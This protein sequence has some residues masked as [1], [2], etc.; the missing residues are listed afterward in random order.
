MKLR[1][2]RPV[3]AG[4]TAATMALTAAGPAAAQSLPDLPIAPSGAVGEL[5]APLED[6][7]A[8]S[9]P[10]WVTPSATSRWTTPSP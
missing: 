2:M 7:W 8:R 5:L 4:L 10:R 3:V 6:L 1:V 9:P